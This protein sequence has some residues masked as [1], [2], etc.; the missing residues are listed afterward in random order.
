[1]EPDITPLQ[2][3]T[4]RNRRS[5]RRRQMEAGDAPLAAPV[6][7]EAPQPHSDESDALT[8]QQR[9]AR[10]ARAAQ[11]AQPERS[12][13]VQRMQPTE[14]GH[15]QPSA[16][17]VQREESAYRRPVMAH[18]AEIP[19]VREESAYRRPAMAQPQQ[20]PVRRQETAYRRPPMNRS[21]SLPV[22]RPDAAYRQPNAAPPSAGFSRPSSDQRRSSYADHMLETPVMPQQQ[23][24]GTIDQPVPR[25]IVIGMA[26]MFL[27]LLAS[28]TGRLMMDSYI[29]R[30]QDARAAAYQRVVETHPV[31]YT[32]LI[33]RY[34]GA[35][36]LQ[37]A[38]V[39]SIILN[40]SSYNTHAESNVGARGLMQLMPD[41]A[42]WIAHKLGLDATYNVEQLWQAETNIRFGC[43][44]LNYLSKQF[45]GDPVTVASAYHAGQGEIASWLNNRTYAP[46]GRSL[47]LASMPE[48]PT[49]VYAGRVTRDYAIYDALYFH[50]FNQD[51]PDA[52]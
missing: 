44:Y 6:P 38:F 48:G 36:N 17:P 49:K 4:V 52:V 29:V 40:E 50:A 34:A 1:M 23:R 12:A 7:Q 2:P 26:V 14:A 20:A 16:A 46:D 41:T 43:W 31:Q 24:H 3:E 30:Q 33:S 28:V 11:Q 21:G 8:P 22:V 18:S 5:D 47:S 15:A 39:A 27:V 13:P 37:P 51:A 42:Q 19:V 25:W 10:Y 9:Y 35:Y 32:D 45:S